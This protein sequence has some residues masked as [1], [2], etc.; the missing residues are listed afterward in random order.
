MDYDTIAFH[1]E[2]N[3]PEKGRRA[4]D[5]SFDVYREGNLKTRTREMG[6]DLRVKERS[7]AFSVLA[8]PHKLVHGESVADHFGP[9]DL[10]DWAHAFGDMAGLDPDG[11]LDARVGRFDVAANLH[12]PRPA[13][14]YVPR[15]Y[16]PTRP[17]PQRHGDETVT[18]KYSTRDVT[19]YDKTKKV[20]NRKRGHHLPPS[21]PNGR[22]LRA[23]VRF[24]SPA[25]EFGRLV[26]VRD[27]CD[28]AFWEVACGRWLRHVRAVRVSDY[29]AVPPAASVP[30]LQRTYEEIG[31]GDAKV[32]M[33]RTGG[34]EAAFARVRD[35]LE[36][37]LIGGRQAKSQRA[38]LRELTRDHD[39]RGVDPIPD[40]TCETSRTPAY[41][42]A[43]AVKL[44]HGS[45]GPPGAT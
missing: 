43:L 17:N 13:S 33:E 28:A 21:W 32:G 26:L 39:L 41:E 37:G 14:E 22:V 34:P 44:A 15:L 5:T 10:R 3:L 25:K 11:V 38:R 1:V 8:S 12:L 36:A 42:L 24:T 6:P 40:S 35:N 19:F 18:F 7:E 20:L 9:S 2:G 16:E 23:E 30:E 45:L 27:L 4:L 29:P 31:H